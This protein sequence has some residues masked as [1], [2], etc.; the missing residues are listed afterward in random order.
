MPATC[1]RGLPR[2]AGVVAAA[3]A[4]ELAAALRAWFA[5]RALS[6]VRS[7]LCAPEGYECMHRRAARR[8]APVLALLRCSSPGCLLVSYMPLARLECSRKRK[9][10]LD[11]SKS[12]Q[13]V[14]SDPTIQC[15]NRSASMAPVK[16]SAGSETS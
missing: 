9:A 10:G 16:M 3:L 11:G 15:H 6:V 7:E 5:L 14:H 2:S 8:L 12:S 13:V 4:C 1:F